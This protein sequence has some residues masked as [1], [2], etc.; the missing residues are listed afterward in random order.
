MLFIITLLLKEI[1]LINDNNANTHKSDRWSLL[2]SFCKHKIENASL[3]V[4]VV[5]IIYIINTYQQ[6]IKIK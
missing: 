4:L 5:S 3:S 1:S 2:T 6:L